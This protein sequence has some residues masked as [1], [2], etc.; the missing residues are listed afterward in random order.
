MTIIDNKSRFVVKKIFLILFFTLIY[1]VS[2]KA[3]EV[4]CKINDTKCEVGVP[5]SL[6]LSEDVKYT[7]W[8]VDGVKIQ[9]QG[10]NSYIPQESDYENWI[11]VEGYNENDEV[12]GEDKIFFSKLP[13]VYID[14]VNNE[15][16]T[17]R[18]EYIKAVMYVQGNTSFDSQ[19]NGGID[20]KARGNSTY[21]LP[22]KPYKLKLDTST[23]MFGFGKNKHW[24]LLANYRDEALVR[25]TIADDLSKELGLVGFD[26]T[27]VDVIMND[28]YIGNYQFCEQIRINE[29][30][31]NIFNWEEEAESIAKELYK[32]EKHNGMSKDDR[33]A[34][35]NI[36]QNDYS[37][38]TDDRIVYSDTEYNV[39]DYYKF[40]TNI[41]GGYLFELNEYLS[42]IDGEREH[43]EFDT[44]NGMR[45]VIDK[46]EMAISNANMMFF[47]KEYWDDF[48]KAYNS[49]DGYYNNKHYSQYADFDSMVS[50]WLL[51]EIVGNTDA[52]AR[53]RL[54][55]MDV[56]DVIYFG[57][58]WDYDFGFGI[59]T[60]SM[61]DTKWKFSHSDNPNNLFKNWID[62]PL[63]VIKAQEK[64]WKIRPYLN[65]IVSSGGLLDEYNDYLYESGQ[66]ND[67]I[68]RWVRGYDNDTLYV[69]DYLCRR[70]SWLDEQ[71]STQDSIINSLYSEVSDH[72]YKRA[73]EKI[74]IAFNNTFSD[75]SELPYKSDGIVKDEYDL[76][77]GVGIN[78][79]ETSTINIYINGLKLDSYD[80]VSSLLDVTIPKEKLNE[81][82]GTKNVIS[83][84]G[85]NNDGDV[86]YTNFAT[87]IQQDTEIVN[88]SP[89]ILSSDGV[90]SYDATI[91]HIIINQIYGGKKSASYASNDFIEL[92]NPT[93]EDVNLSGWSLQYRS[94]ID[95][96]DDTSWS[97]LDLTG[98]IK[99]HCSY[100]VKCKAATGTEDWHIN[101]ADCDQEWKQK[102]NNKGCSV[103][104]VANDK[105]ID[106]DS[107]VFDNETGQP[108]ISGYVDMVG[109]SGND[110]ST[111][112]D[113]NN[114]AALHFEKEASK[115]QSRKSAIRRKA[116]ADTD[117]NTVEGDF[118]VVDYSF[119]NA[120]YIA[121]ISPKCTADGAWTYDEDAVPKYAVTI[122]KN[123]KGEDVTELKYI[124]N[125]LFDVPEKPVRE[126]YTFKGWFADKGLT[127]EYD[128]TKKSVSD[129]TLYAGWKVNNYTIR[130]ESNGGE[131]IQ[132][133]TKGYGDRVAEPLEPKFLGGGYSF[134]GWYSDEALETPYE[135]TTM[136]AE[137]ITLYAKWDINSYTIRFVTNGGST[138]AAMTADYGSELTAPKAPLREGYTFIGW[139]ADRKLTL[140]YVF[141]NMPAQDETIY[142]GWEPE[143]HTIS[144]ES[145]GGSSVSSVAGNYGVEISELTDGDTSV[146]PEK[147]GYT[148][149]G[150]YS[151]EALETP[152]EFTTMPAEDITLYAKWDINSY[153]IRFVTNGESA[154][155]V[156]SYEYG[157]DVEALAAPVK[158]GYTFTGWY[159]DK[160]CTKEYVFSTMPAVNVTV[161]AGWTP[162]KSEVSFDTAGGS[163]VGNVTV[164]YGEEG[165]IAEPVK[166]GASFTGWYVDET[167]TIPYDPDKAYSGSITLHAGW[168]VK[169]YTVR[170]V[171]HDGTVLKSE[172][173]GYSGN[174]TAPEA[175]CRAGYTFTG[176]NSTAENVRAN[177]TVQAEYEKISIVLS[178]KYDM[179][180]NDPAVTVTDENGSSISEITLYTRKYKT[181]QFT[182]KVIGSGLPV[183]WSSSDD[184]VASV[185]SKGKVSVKK[186]GVTYITAEAGGASVR[187]KVIVKQAGIKAVL[188]GKTAGSKRIT[189]KKGARYKLKVTA[190]PDGKVTYK[191]KNK[192]IATVSGK[193]TITT[194]KKGKTTI[195]ISSNGMKKTVKI[196]VK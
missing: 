90:L 50:Y 155:E 73:L 20:I 47:I 87:V 24:V 45:V 17:S 55:Y 130:F 184:S 97:K 21:Y 7:K 117:D 16:I 190:I 185:S 113:I 33:D 152:Y 86:T 59:P 9:L 66:A 52:N 109:V 177:L 100:L 110:V 23:D 157:A 168:K 105:L 164:T 93:D 6:T 78:D 79:D 101:I 15:T 10:A 11:K 36:M 94:S 132:S 62:D 141:A 81:E 2:V 43:S 96:G 167:C 68:W 126:G 44:S 176:W 151:D 72:P 99:S 57:P 76:K 195:V 49:Q 125:T 42:V 163:G 8:Y 188:N 139:Y 127:K 18:D 148:F 26:T 192:K 27:W 12:I 137:D 28:S 104:L 95:G 123:I 158:E 29:N 170:W 128:F 75:N 32:V 74:P 182:G 63:F 38:I 119:E 156:R 115:V 116:F 136:P 173:V 25:N 48:E 107:P 82:K 70:I 133:I 69:K 39:S 51:N 13:V 64:Y 140:P 189:L 77:M 60:D 144:F 178:A 146:V 142:A 41:T 181:A 134:A 160:K 159:S 165:E 84:I 53:S 175:P 143:S 80:V 35:E 3:N 108:V 179:S 56:D 121:Y 71:F 34:I 193:G 149:A 169:E 102:I 54:C 186:A 187:C 88:G 154:V 5:L 91:P 31:V 129:V 166:E 122:D 106:P 30:R 161:Y 58:V 172:K 120:D 40:N 98:T 153:T 4:V 174:G 131:E 180:V 85:Y 19:Y 89:Y 150:W 145:N 111:E 46:P 112:E 147:E 196:R 191:S 103:V 135:F 162:I 1:S 118:E 171:D 61:P 83:I 65:S 14:T 183:T 92:Y 37:W 67:S 194:K 124:Y 138:V 22:K 114:E